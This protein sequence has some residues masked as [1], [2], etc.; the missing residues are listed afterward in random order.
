MLAIFL[1]FFYIAPTF[2]LLDILHDSGKGI[3]NLFVAYLVGRYIALHGFPHKICGLKWFWGL[4]IVIVSI[5]FI[6]LAVTLA[7]GTL[8]QKM[9]RDNSIFTLLEAVA[10]LCTI[11]QMK[12]RTIKWVNNLASYVFPIYVI[13]YALIPRLVIIPDSTHNILYLMIWA[14]AISIS[15][16][17]I[18]LELIR[19]LIFKKS[20]SLLIQ[21][22]VKLTNR[23]IKHL[24]LD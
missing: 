4:I 17:S 16:I 10:V 2:L 3:V 5:I 6:N 1:L 7:S 13:H 19:R 20:F 22:E 18:G 15:L 12:P 24:Q 14:N 11:L 23:C 21:L 9:S 8:F